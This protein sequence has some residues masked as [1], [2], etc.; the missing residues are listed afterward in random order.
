M[1]KWAKEWFQAAASELGSCGPIQGA[2]LSS[3][4][5]SL[6]WERY[7]LTRAATTDDI[8]LALSAQKFGDSARKSL[9]AVLTTKTGPSGFV[10]PLAPASPASPVEPPKLARELRKNAQRA[11]RDLAASTVYTSPEDDLPHHDEVSWF[12]A[13]ASQ[14]D[15][16]RDPFV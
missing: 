11:Q 3:A 8:G 1:Y 12:G 4:A 2:L 14:S 15:P 16:S 9:A 6:A 10:D 13:S 5:A 7:L